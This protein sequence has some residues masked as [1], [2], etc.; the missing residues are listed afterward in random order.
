MPTASRKSEPKDK[1]KGSKGDLYS[2]SDQ[3]VKIMRMDSEGPGSK[4]SARLRRNME[5]VEMLA[6]PNSRRLR[7]LWD[8]KCAILP[9]DRRDKIKSALE[10]DYFLSPEQTEQ[11]FQALN[12]SSRRWSGPGGM[13][14]RKEHV[15][16]SKELRQRQKWLVNFSA[17]V[18]YR[19]CDYIA[20]GQKEMLVSNRLRAIADVVLE[21]VAEILGEP[22]PTRTNP[23]RLPRFM[24]AIS[25]RIAVWIENAVYRADASEPIGAVKGGDE[26]MRLDAEKPLIC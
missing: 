23:G 10:E 12:E 22:K 15:D 21:R 16:R 11:Y 2:G 24:V 20:K 19:L 6:R 17:Q 14:S 5:R 1:V 3:N 8:E 25:D 13:V 4:M 9:R 26:H 18:A 7:S